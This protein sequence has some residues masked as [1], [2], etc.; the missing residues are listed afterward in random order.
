MVATM[1]FATV[2][3]VVAVGMVASR[4][5]RDIT[6]K[7]KC[8]A[9]PGCD[10]CVNRFGNDS[11]AC[12]DVQTETCCNST[13]YNEGNHS[14]LLCGLRETCTTYLEGYVERP[15]CCPV[16]LKPCVEQRA[17]KDVK[18]PGC[19]NPATEQCCEW[20]HVP[21]MGQRVPPQRHLLWRMGRSV[22]L[23]RQQHVL[24]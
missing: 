9:T 5:C 21:G 11:F 6:G 19:Y 14:V 17:A 23:R 18:Y 7:L 15:G 13:T 20:F 10:A 24:R 16:G 3:V 2:L 4:R 8:L 12:F 22:L 1:R